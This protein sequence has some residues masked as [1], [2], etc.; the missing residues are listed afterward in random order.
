M[1][2]SRVQ[3]ITA[4]KDLPEHDLKQIALLAT[5]RS[6]PAGTNLV[7]QDDF[8]NDV[9]GIL[10]GSAEVIQNGERVAVLQVGD[11]LGEAGVIDKA[12]RG[13]TVTATEPMLIVTL[14]RVEINRLR[15]VAPDVITRLEEIV[16]AR[17]APSGD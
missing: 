17:H 3:I 16:D 8:S 5:E 11:I 1:D 6:V 13:A 12:R 7:E 15:K 10:E 2:T 14:G 4:F 9:I